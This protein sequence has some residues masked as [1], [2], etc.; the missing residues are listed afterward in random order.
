MATKELTEQEQARIRQE[1]AREI[2][3]AIDGGPMPAGADAGIAALIQDSR[4]GRFMLMVKEHQAKT[5]CS[6]QTAM[7]F[8]VRSHPALHKAFLD[9]AN[10]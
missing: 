2:L 9:S 5:K 10:R 3:R 6:R 7:S 8:V 1:I 4:A